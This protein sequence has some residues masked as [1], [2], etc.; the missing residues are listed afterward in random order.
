MYILDTDHL[1]VLDRATGPD[2]TRLRARLAVVPRA[3]VA[4]T[5]ISF[6]EQMRGWLAFL[7][8]AHSV[9]DQVVAYQRLSR[10]LEMYCRIPVLTRNAIDF[11]RI[12]GLTIEDWT[13]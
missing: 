2:A 1:S 13:C 10:Q 8:R 4:T 9:A 7:A 6:E 5:I 11:R 3:E 12:P